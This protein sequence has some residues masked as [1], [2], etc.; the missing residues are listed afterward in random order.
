MEI[1]NE[2]ASLKQ[3]NYIIYLLSSYEK[4]HDK[5]EQLAFIKKLVKKEITFDNLLMTEAYSIIG[6]I[7]LKHNLV[8]TRES[9]QFKSNSHAIAQGKNF[10]IGWQ[11]H[12]DKSPLAYFSFK[13]L[14]VIDWDNLSLNEIKEILKKEASDLT[15]AIY[16]TYN[17]YHGYCI[18]KQFDINY[19]TLKFMKVLKCDPL[20][21]QFCIKNGFIVRLNKKQF[22]DEQFVEKYVTNVGNSHL[23]QNLYLLLKLKDM[24]ICNN[25]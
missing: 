13:N 22:R 2:K 23:N 19:K 24:S 16:Q 10:E 20:Y 15:F 3:I 1:T 12:E 5:N 6:K 14:L 4:L 11:L 8:D 18:S 21:I 17:G 7:K 9:M 25:D